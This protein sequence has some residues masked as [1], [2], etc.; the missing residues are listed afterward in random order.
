M[1]NDQHLMDES[2]VPDNWVSAEVAK[3]TPP[4]APPPRPDMPSLFSGSM[5]PQTQHDVSFVGTKTGSS[6]IPQHSLMPLGVQGN[7]ASNAA[8]QSTVIKQIN[9]NVGSNITLQTN[10]SNNPNQQIL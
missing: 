10:G 5:P 3:V 6:R 2:Q 8:V 9:N 4:S 1:S 7:P